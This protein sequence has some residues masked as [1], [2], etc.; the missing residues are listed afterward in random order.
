MIM[1]W[2]NN[3]HIFQYFRVGFEN[4]VKVTLIIVNTRED[5]LIVASL[6]Q[7]TSLHY[8]R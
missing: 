8:N 2:L 7:I 6:R 5:F 3:L 1:N 4:K